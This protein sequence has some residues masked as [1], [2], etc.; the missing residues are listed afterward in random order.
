MR[1]GKKIAVMALATTL[2]SAACSDSDSGSGSTA[3]RAAAAPATTAA[4]GVTQAPSATT[5]AAPAATEAPAVSVEAADAVGPVRIGRPEEEPPRDEIIIVPEQRFNQ[6]VRTSVDPLSTFGLEVDT[7]AYTLMRNW[8]YNG[9]QPN[10][11]SVRVEEYINFFTQDYDAPRVDT[12]AVFA[13]G[14]PSPH[15]GNDLDQILR[16][17]VR[18]KDVAGFERAD[19]VLTLVIDVSGSMEAEGKLGLVQDSLIGLVDELGPGDT[20]AIVAYEET[21]WVV[22]EPT[23]ATE[24][25]EIQ[26]A[27]D[28][29]TP[30]G[31]TNAEAGLSLGYE[32]ARDAF[33][34]GGIN[35]V[36]LMSDGVANVGETDPDGILARIS[37]DAARGITMAAIGVGIET[38]NDVLLETLAD[39]GD[40]FYAYVD[41][42]DQA[43]RLFSEDLVGSLQ[44]VASDAKI[45]ITFDAENGS[46]LPVDW[47]REPC[48]RRRGLH[49]P[50]HRRWRDRGRAH[51]HRSV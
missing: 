15:S 36:V 4:A 43:K 29:L 49:Q 17:G 34:A 5:A 20:V 11:D 48:H 12:F 24:R 6:F 46:Q 27:I 41:N 28:R 50:T 37:E 45:Q 38:Y 39:N 23:P 26:R 21:A 9:I 51:R 19:A 16:I 13:D 32:L 7:G 10:P 18:A 31:S 1:S 44:V 42:L 35:R 3:D 25:R 22:L 33:V 2:V 40:G 30:G 14:A 8:V 47:L